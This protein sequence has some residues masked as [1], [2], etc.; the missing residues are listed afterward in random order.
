MKTLTI[1]G[2]GFDL[3]HGLPTTFDA[4]VKSKP[5]IYPEKYDI[6][7]GAGESWT[8][9][10]NTYGNQLRDILDSRDWHDVL[11]VVDTIVQ[12]YGITEYGNVDYYGY[13]SDAFEE[14]YRDILFRVNLLS[15]FEHDFQKYLLEKCNPEILSNLPMYK[16]I[17]NI[18]DS[19]TRI[20]SFNYTDTVEAVYHIKNVEH[21]HGS[22]HTSIAIGSGALDDA[23]T[24]LVDDIYP[25]ADS[26]SKDKYGLQE[27]L[28]YYDYD[29]D[30]NLTPK[31]FIAQF[32]DEVSSSAKE[33]EEDIFSLVDAKNKDALSSRTH[34]IDSLFAEHYDTVYIL[35]H[36]L[37]DAD[38][39]VLDAINKD[40]N[41]I[42]CYHSENEKPKMENVLQ[43]LG[44]K[45]S[46][47]HNSSIYH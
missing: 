36:A 13:S 16:E 32:F 11:D 5:Y 12:D 43:S 31:T 25:S 34:I 22:I 2:N 7:K 8:E 24:N 38:Y 6:F 30:G 1:I 35:G 37:G 28:F 14:Q 26:F 41:V 9:I 29:E 40:A 15:E 3:G 19:S 17:R 20:I 27:R 33:R 44:L 46:L 4:F 10:E 21:I 42:C 23:K 18:L 47:V 39:S 45:H